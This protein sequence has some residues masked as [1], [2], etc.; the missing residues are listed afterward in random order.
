M[1][2]EFTTENLTVRLASAEDN[3]AICELFR[4]VHMDGEIELNQERDPDYFALCRLHHGTSYSF[5]TRDAKGEPA[6]VGTIIV[7]P[8]WLDGERIQSGYLCDLRMR[9]GFRGGVTLARQMTPILQWAAEQSGA[10]V[11][12]TVIFDDNRLARKVLTGPGAER[13]GQPSYHTMTPF[14]MYSVQF[15]RGRRRPSERIRSA[16]KDDLDELRAFLASRGQQRTLGEDFTG[17]LLDRRL[18]EWPG[19]SLDDFLLARD[20]SGRIVG[21]L[22]PW[23]TTSVKRTRVLAYHRSMAWMKRTLDIGSMLFRFPRL[24]DAGECFRFAFLTHLEVAEDDPAVFTDLLRAAYL[25]LR[26]RDLHFMSAF[27]PRNSPLE[28]SFR[29]F[30]VQRTAM[31]LYA[32]PVPGGR[33]SDRRLWTAAHPGFEMALS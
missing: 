11:F 21:C 15:T 28:T 5:L 18:A 14:Q 23:D 16:T 3:D 24:P 33:F 6:A 7:R 27:V 4:G 25:R 9:P 8:A 30:M 17:D 1:S 22:A 2:Y 13:R 12:N 26:G 31:T 32:V 10:D 20:D 29:G 19:F